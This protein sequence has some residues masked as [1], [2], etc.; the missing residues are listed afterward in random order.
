MKD[1]ANRTSDGG[2]SKH[3]G[4]IRAHIAGLLRRPCQSFFIRLGGTGAIA[5]WK[6]GPY[7]ELNP[8]IWSDI[9]DIDIL[10]NMPDWTLHRGVEKII[11]QAAIEHGDKLKCAIICSSGVYGQGRG[12]GRT[13]SLLIPDFYSEMLK[14]GASFYTQSGGNSRGWVHLDDLMQ[15]YLK[16]IEAA[17]AGGGKATWGIEVSSSRH[18]ARRS[19]DQLMAR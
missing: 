3:E 15:I 4:V 12:L 1:R 8:K 18:A 9:E 13:Q 2:K 17:A 7:G 10:T 11:Q 6:D 16:L 5:D 14:L 19:W